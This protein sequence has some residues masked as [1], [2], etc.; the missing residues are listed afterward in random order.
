VKINFRQIYYFVS[1]IVKQKN[2]IYLE[3][4]YFLLFK[5]TNSQAIIIPRLIK[6]LLVEGCERGDSRLSH[7]LKNPSTLTGEVQGGGDEYLCYQLLMCIPSPLSPP[8][9][10]GDNIVP[11]PLHGPSVFLVRFHC[12]ESFTLLTSRAPKSLGQELCIIC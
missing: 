11:R 10:G 9:R 3:T 6:G 7:H 1:R 2:H 12:K 8:A 4:M 5:S